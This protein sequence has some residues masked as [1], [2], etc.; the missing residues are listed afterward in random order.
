PLTKFGDQVR[1][2]VVV[3]KGL[4]GH[5]AGD[6]HTAAVIEENV[7]LVQDSAKG[8]IAPRQ[9]QRVG[10]HDV[11]LPTLAPSKGTC[12]RSMGFLSSPAIEANPQK[13][14]LLAGRRASIPLGHSG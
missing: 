2:D 3:E 8:R 4:T 14:H 6:L 9:V 1:A 5:S 11:N 7:R 13:G 12:E 10:V